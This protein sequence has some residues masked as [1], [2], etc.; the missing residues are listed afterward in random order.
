MPVARAAKASIFS[1]PASLTNSV[2]CCAALDGTS[3]A[4]THS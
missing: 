3:P 2:S 4:G 1:A